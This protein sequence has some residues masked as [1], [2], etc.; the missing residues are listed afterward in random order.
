MLY[1]VASALFA[2]RILR[3]LG[4]GAK[5]A[6]LAF[7]AG[8]LIVAAV[9]DMLDEAHAAERDPQA[10]ILAFLGGFVLFTLVSSGLASVVGG[11]D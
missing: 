5:A 6:A 7:P 1:G 11:G 9:E 8:L 10:S 4:A 3:D 2:H